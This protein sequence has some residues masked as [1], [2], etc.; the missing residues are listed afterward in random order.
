MEPR[1]NSSSLQLST[2]LRQG[3]QSASILMSIINTPFIDRRIISEDAIL[4]A[5][6]LMRFHIMKNVVPSLSN[7]GHL[8]LYA[9]N[10]NTKGATTNN[11]ANSSNSSSNN[12]KLDDEPQK[13]RC[14]KSSSAPI[15]QKEQKTYQKD[16]QNFLMKAYKPLLTMTIGHL[17]LL[18]EK[19]DVLIKTLQVDDQPLLSICSS[20]LST[21]T[22]D[23]TSFISSS[24]QLSQIHVVQ[25]C[26]INLVSTVFRQY[27]R[28]R[29]VI[30]E[31]LFPLFMK[32]PT[33][34][35]SMRT[36]PVRGL[37]YPGMP[38]SSK[39]NVNTSICNRVNF[40]SPMKPNLMSVDADSQQN[41]IQVMTALILHLIQ[42][43]I[44][45]PIQ[46]KHVEGENGIGTETQH[47]PTII[48]PNDTPTDGIH[49][50]SAGSELEANK[51]QVT[52]SGLEQCE[53]VC[54]QFTN[55]LIQRCAKK[56]DEGGA[57]EF[58]PILYNLIDDLLNV[59][60]L[61]EFPAAEM[62]LM[63]IIRML[64]NVLLSNSS[65]MKGRDDIMKKK[66]INLEQTFLGTCL[67]AVGTICSDIASK[68]VIAKENPLVFTKAIKS[69]DLVCQDIV[70]P[71]EEGSQEVNGC[72]CGRAKSNVFSLDCDRCHRW[73]HGNCLRI[74]KDFT[75]SH[76][77]CDECKMILLASKQL[78]LEFDEEKDLGNEERLHIMRIVMLNFL[79]HQIGKNSQSMTLKDARQFHIAKIVKE[80][81]S[82]IIALNG[83]SLVSSLRYL[84]MWNATCFENNQESPIIKTSHE[85]LS[86]AGNT[87][88]MVALNGIQ[89]EL[90]TNF[91][92]FLGALITLMG[93]VDVTYLRKG[94]VKAISQVMQADSSLMSKKMIKEAISNRFN[95]SAISVREAVV[96]LVGD[97]VL[98]VP[99]RAS[100][101][102]DVL[103]DR[104]ND[105]GVSVVST[106]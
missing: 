55:H 36:F 14:R 71:F 87:K 105:N 12:N 68:L 59:Q 93:D 76:W 100:I 53:V 39:K 23:P 2:I 86:E 90:A 8:A 13:K 63:E 99:D 62:L 50:E 42:S 49:D 74:A 103:L 65:A 96:K 92:K 24:E 4:A 20:S 43:C 3:L 47:E 15:H 33:S 97:Y 84:N 10:T 21:L 7:T 70:N 102:H 61:P 60:L 88:V 58:R 37:S 66:F 89:S 95:D 9:T 82:M 44:T 106:N 18:M 73:F 34:K 98:Q 28:H 6:T 80:T 67:D 17:I 56:G 78:G 54:K 72:F 91:P 16:L 5:I 25:S 57:S 27:T 31:D 35:R 83:Q 32:L 75:P 41:Y 40:V 101:F 11:N 22:I 94:A 81:D 30:L 69:E 46:V 45:V 77:N 48:E 52:T 1:R 64:T 104:S 26:A 51:T 19:I 85:Y 38:S 29:I 79:S